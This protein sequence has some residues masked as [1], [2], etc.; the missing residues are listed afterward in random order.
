MIEMAKIR[1]FASPKI[2]L[3]ITLTGLNWGVTDGAM[4]LTYRLENRVD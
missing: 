3:G 1:E 4:R 2:A